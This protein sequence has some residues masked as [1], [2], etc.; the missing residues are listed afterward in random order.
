[1]KDILKNVCTILAYATVGGCFIKLMSSDYNIELHT[2]SNEIYG[3]RPKTRWIASD[4]GLA[5]AIKAINDSDMWSSDKCEAISAIKHNYSPD[6]YYAV[7]SIA[8]SDMWSSDKRDTIKKIF[9]ES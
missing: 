9:E 5:K 3:P 4:R 8:N 1:M 7:I 2:I 6:V